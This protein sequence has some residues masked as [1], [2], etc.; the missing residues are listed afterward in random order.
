MKPQSYVVAT[1]PFDEH[2]FTTNAADGEHGIIITSPYSSQ[3]YCENLFQ[4]LLTIGLSEFASFLDHQCATKSQP[5]LW[6][7]TLEK[8]IKINMNAFSTSN[9]LHRHTK[10]I[11]Q[12]CIKRHS[13]Q[14]KTSTQNHIPK[15]KVNG[16]T[17]DKEYSFS[18][19]KDQSSKY[20]TTDEKVAF[21][22]DQIFEY[23]L[24]PPEY[25]NQKELAFDTQCE[26]EIKRLEK[27]EVMQQKIQN[28]KIK[29]TAT[30]KLPYEGDLK[31]LCDIFYKLMRKK[32]TRGNTF[33]P[34][35][36]AQATDH[37]CNSYCEP[38][39]TALNPST[40]RT[41]LSSSKP[42]S[43]PKIEREFDID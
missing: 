38:D 40:V 39:G 29:A 15:M 6:L 17:A 2:N 31:V 4:K 10:L 16:F 22:Q 11:F 37:I 33:F 9:L 21:L 3:K 27:Q 26:L 42:E 43:R 25:I 13:L 7:N 41:Y 23:Q 20:E 5:V 28:R 1:I 30:A 34:W 18:N 32:S 12:I 19:I 14:E 24:N 8:L 35:S 36:I